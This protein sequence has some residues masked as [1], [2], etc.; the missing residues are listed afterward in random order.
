V[1][2]DALSQEAAGNVFDT[3]VR[4]LRTGFRSVAVLALLVALAAFLFGP[5]TAATRTRAALESGI[6]SAR[7]GAE[8]AGWRAGRVGP[9]VLA[10]TRALRAGVF[11]AA[12]LVLLFWTRPTV[13]VVVVTALLVGVALVLI[14]FLGTPPPPPQVV[15][16]AG[17][18]E[19]PGASGEPRKQTEVPDRDLHLSDK[20]PP[21][22]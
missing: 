2:P 11:L 12:G 19:E 8:Q 22:P 17:A 13:L 15:A 1:P 18:G 7:T 20:G 6:G 10:H 3:L 4:F 16:G 9:W 21:S 14:E 5:S